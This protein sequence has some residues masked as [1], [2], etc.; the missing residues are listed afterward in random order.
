MALK[1]SNAEG[2]TN[3]LPALLKD[4]DSEVRFVGIK[5]IADEKL[6]GYVS[7]LKAVLDR[8]DLSRRDLLAV[9]AALARI[10]GGSKREF[11]PSDTLLELALDTDKPPGLRAMAL[12]NVKVDH[13]RLTVAILAPLAKSTHQRIRR[14]AVHSLVIHADPNRADV[15]AEIAADD[16]LDENLRADA[17]A[18]L[19]SVA[20]GQEELL[21]TL[22]SDSNRV[23]SEEATRTRVASGLAERQVEAKPK[24]EQIEQWTRLI[25]REAT[26][27]PDAAVGRRLFFHSKLAGCYKC[28]AIHGRGNSVGPDLTSIHNQTDV[29]QDWLLKHIVNPNAEMAPYYR[30]QQLITVDG[31]VLVGLIVGKE[32]KKQGYVANDGHV[33]YVDKDDV[34]K[35]RE[36]TTS[37]MPNGL[38]DAMSVD[39]IR[40]LLAFLLSG[41]QRNSETVASNSRPIPGS[42]QRKERIHVIADFE[43]DNF[44]EG[45]KTSHK[46]SVTLVDDVP[47]GGGKFAV[48]AAIDPDAGTK[49]F[50]GTGFRI[51]VTDFSRFGEIRFWVKAD[52]ESG[53]N[54]QCSSGAGKT[55]VFP[56]TTVGSVGTWKLISAPVAKF[57]KPPWAKNSADL[58]AI[59]FFQVT[60]FGTPP[61]D[62]KTILL[63]DVVGV[64]L[65]RSTSAPAGRGMEKDGVESKSDERE[66]LLRKRAARLHEPK[67][68]KSSEPVDMFDGETLDGWFTSPR[69]YVPRNEKFANMPSD[70]LYDE[71]IKF[72]EENEGGNRIPNQE[73]VKNRGVWEIKDGAV[74]G[75]QVPGS[76]AGSYLISEKT[77]G[78]FELTLEANPDFPIDTG[79][80]VRAHKLGSVGY[81]VLVDNRP[82]GSIGGVYGNSVGSFLAWPFTI[83]GD[84]EPGNKIANIREGVAE[85]N[86]LRGGKFKS[87]YSGTFAEFNKA[88][89]PN[90]W[91][92]IKVRCTGRLA[93]YRDLD[94]RS[95]CIEAGHGNSRRRGSELRCR[96]DL[97]SYWKEGAHRVRGSR[98]SNAPA[99][100]T[101][102]EMPLE[103][104]THSG[105]GD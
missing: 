22:S 30:P 55:S 105:A 97:Q 13:P 96:S 32:G 87:D 102:S 92:N 84:E 56:F 78:D 20:M 47:E 45:K 1:R 89:K 12:A 2:R 50:F 99:L 74:I 49:N 10:T 91:N 70:R 57:G 90:D 65:S 76:I 101:R 14:E 38:L 82:N 35:R 6:T 26:E 5:W 104:R 103:E 72:Y 27:K 77:Y 31:K 60:T 16:S 23:I 79:I 40:H 51:P 88:W 18:G 7:N 63:D 29:T 48:R 39:E 17:I 59:H 100:G 61:Y 21:G 73:R 8:S 71:V 4:K 42:V 94:Q 9:V 80:M 83:D 86:P 28:H 3:I 95:S 15:L 11:S 44:L 25:N 19:A 53:F 24:A 34:E 36:M 62:G 58:K 54:F 43:D 93:A 68:L 85:S 37:I 75:G 52:F 46:A 33:F 66:A 64:P 98:Q 67:I 81:Q 69:V 41:Q